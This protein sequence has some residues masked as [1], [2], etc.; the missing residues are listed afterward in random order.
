MAW[1]CPL[2]L[3]PKGGVTT[4]SLKIPQDVC[5]LPQKCGRYH[6]RCEAALKRK[7]T[8]AVTPSFPPSFLRYSFP[9]FSYF[10]LPSLPP[11]F[12]SIF[13]YSLP[14][15]SLSF[16]PSFH[17]SF[18]PSVL[19]FPPADRVTIEPQ[20]SCHALHH[21]NNRASRTID[22][23]PTEATFRKF[24]MN[25]SGRK[26]KDRSL[27]IFHPQTILIFSSTAVVATLCSCIFY[28]HSY[29]PAHLVLNKI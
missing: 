7:R 23:L 12:P 11:P 18:L 16:F 29:L 24:P 27:C 9:P 13:P 19:L 10:L 14:S 21:Q 6:P 1:S 26:Y 8:Q 20:T 17:P 22:Y 28:H 4:E 25:H 3:G 5:P 15:L 2:S